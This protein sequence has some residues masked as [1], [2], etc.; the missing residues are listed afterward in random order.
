MAYDY[1]IVGAGSAGCVLANRLTEDDNTKV[2]L[3]EAG[4]PDD[5]PEFHIPIAFGGLFRGEND[6][7]YVTQPEPNLNN[8]TLY[9]P[10][11][12]V[13]GGSSSINA[14]I[15]IRGHRSTYD[16]WAENGN[17]GWS[18]AEVLPY[19]KKSQHQER[20]ASEYHGVGGG[21]NTADQRDTNPLSCA[22]VDACLEMGIKRNVDFNGV[23]QDGCGFFQVTQKEGRRCSSAG[24]F[25]SP[26][27]NRPN[28]T[29]KTHAMVTKVL[30][31]GKRA[32]GVSYLQDG[33]EHSVHASCEVL[34]AGGAIN[35][36][37]LLML[38]GIGPAE[39]LKSLDIPVLMDLPGVGQNLR[40]HIAVFV[41]YYSSEP[42][43]LANAG[44]IS[45]GLIYKYFAKGPLSSNLGEA[46]AFVKTKTNLTMPDLAFNFAPTWFLEHGGLQPAGHGFTFVPT[47]MATE[48]HGWL[49]LKS[50]DPFVAPLIQPNYFSCSSDMDILVEG[51]KMAR[52]AAKTEAL[53][54]LVASEFRPGPDV[55]SDDEIRNFIRQ[56]AETLYHPVGTCKMG[57]DEMSVVNSKLQ[58]HGIEGL[59][60]VDTSI[61][62][63]I[64]NGNT[65]APAVMIGEKAADM[66]K[67]AK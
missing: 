46:G 31:E 44:T 55:Q 35:S 16:S 6:W 63:T 29:I 36:P 3:L 9:W 65:N 61:M 60:I 45:A 4:G 39:H 50:N 62:P 33:T 22:F 24:A 66:I 40:D 8:R 26:I 57:K 49:K 54:P 53:K 17:N 20:G 19:F 25:L 51:V 1:I 28:L 23:E 15:Y 11:G 37:Q 14:M 27:L 12:K 7:A 59:R 64:T 48:S 13:L 38:S 32:V 2:L 58:V 52:T 41:A 10:R 43:S 56:T 21:L 30:F 34:L 5:K 18:F 47:A 67:E 42:V